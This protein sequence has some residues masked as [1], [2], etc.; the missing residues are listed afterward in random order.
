M[1]RHTESLYRL[2]H[3]ASGSWKIHCIQV[4]DRFSAS[5]EATKLYIYHYVT[6]NV[7]KDLATESPHIRLHLIH[8]DDTQRSTRITLGQTHKSSCHRL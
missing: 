1:R 3:Y 2:Q 6:M 5:N 7:N 8:I 4:I